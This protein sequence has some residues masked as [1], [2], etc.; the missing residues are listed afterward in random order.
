M[1]RSRVG[2]GPCIGLSG[3][4]AREEDRPPGIRANEAIEGPDIA[5]CVPLLL[6]S[7]LNYYPAFLRANLRE[8]VRM[9]PGE[10]L[11]PRPR[12]RKGLSAPLSNRS[13]ILPL[14]SWSSF[15]KTM[16]LFWFH[17]AYMWS[18]MVPF[19][20]TSLVTV[21]RPGYLGV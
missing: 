2:I 15:G 7:L 5:G 10:G 21:G 4:G 17:G 6:P 16:A 13:L 8:L 11:A 18:D 3:L 20:V 12:L 14:P 1:G 9:S 19:P